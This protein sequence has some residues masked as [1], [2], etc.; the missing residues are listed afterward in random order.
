MIGKNKKIKKM[1]FFD[2]RLN[3]KPDEIE[4]APAPQHCLEE[5][6]ET[7]SSALPDWP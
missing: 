1:N 2:F 7:L 5:C 6:L 3:P 4:N